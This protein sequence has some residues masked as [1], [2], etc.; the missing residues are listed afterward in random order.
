MRNTPIFSRVEGK[1][2]NFNSVNSLKFFFGSKQNAKRSVEGKKYER[3]TLIV[4][5][6]AGLKTFDGTVYRS[7]G[8]KNSF[9]ATFFGESELF[10]TPEK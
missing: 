4:G 6:I 9:F 10:Q 2:I 3:R 8:N 1:R 5:T 7:T